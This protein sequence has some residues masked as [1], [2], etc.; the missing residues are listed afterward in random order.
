MP[1]VLTVLYKQ[2]N[3]LLYRFPVWLY[4]LLMT[5]SGG[6]ITQHT[7]KPLAV[8]LAKCNGIPSCISNRLVNCRFAKKYVGSCTEDPK[9]VRTIAGPTPRYSP[10][11]PSAE[12][13]CRVPS[14]A[15]L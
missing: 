1:S 9:P 7:T 10:F 11:M 4:I 8:L 12:Y 5:V 6:C 13:I 3:A 15:F 2:S 14:A